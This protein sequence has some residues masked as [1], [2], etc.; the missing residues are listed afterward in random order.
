MALF[1]K[2]GPNSEGEIIIATHEWSAAVAL[3]A[4]GMANRAKIIFE[5]NLE[6]S[7][8]AQLDG[9]L[10]IIDALDADG[11]AKYHGKVESLGIFREKGSIT[12]AQHMSLLGL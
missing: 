7:D 6:V 5:F 8:E 4:L 12:K 1:D 10:A 3:Y 2:L 9:W 11:K